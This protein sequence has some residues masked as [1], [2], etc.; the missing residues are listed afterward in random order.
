MKNSLRIFFLI[1]LATIGYQQVFAQRSVSGKVTASDDGS[2]LPGVNVILQGTD[3]G[4]ITD[5]N[6]DYRINIPEAGGTLVFSFIGYATQ[7][8]NIGNQSVI[9]MQLKPDVRQLTEVVVTAFGI[10]RERRSLNYSTQEVSAERINI[11]PQPNLT[12]ALQGKIAGVIVKQSSGMP[13][14]S[15]FVTIRGSASL[16]GANQPLYVVDGV[17]IESE[18]IFVDAATVSRVSG[19]DASS[20][21]LDINPEDV[22]SV[23]VLKGAAA[24][25]LYGLRASN[26]VILITTRRG[27]GAELGKPTV[28]FSTN[29]NLDRVTRLPR[30]QSTYSQGSRGTFVPGTS[31][32]W[33][34]R[35]DE[36]GTYINNVGEEVEGRVYDNQTPLFQTGGTLSS[37]INVAGRNENGN[38]SVG[39]G[40]TGQ[41][42]VIPTTG[43]ER[44]NAKFAGDY[45]LGSKWGVGASVNYSDLSVDKVPSGSNLSNPLFT[46]YF[47]PRSYDLWGTPY[48]FEDD[49]YRQI[50][51]RSNMDNPRWSLENNELS[52]QTRRTI[53]NILLSYNPL[54]WITFNYRLGLDQ[55]TTQA[56]EVYEKG[57]GETGGRTNP[58]SGGQITDF[59]FAQ[60]QINS[61]LNVTFDKNITE[62]IHIN[63]LAGNELYDIRSQELN[64]RGTG[65][66]IGGYHNMSNTA[67][68][69][70]SEIIN[71]NRVVG[72][73]GSLT[74]AWRRMLFLTATGRNDFVSN[75][76]TN[77]RSF[78]YPSLGGSFVFTEL[79]DLPENIISFGKVRAS[80]AQ[81]GQSAPNPYSTQNIF[82]Q[83][84]TGVGGFLNDGIQFPFA[85]RNAFTQSNIL[86]SNEL[87]PINTSTFE[88]GAEVRFLN[89]RINL[90][91]TYYIISATDQIFE[92]PLAPSTGFTDELRNAGE[93]ETKGHE[94]VLGLIPIQTSNFTWEI[95]ANY[96]SFTNKVVSLAPGVENIYLGGF[97]TPS[98]RAFAGQNYPS[99]F[100]VGYL[101]DDQGNI[102]L[103]NQ[104]GNPSHGM[105]IADPTA[106]V[107]GNA[108]PDFDIGITNAFSF[109][110]IS[111]MAQVDWRKGG[112]MYSGNSRLGR[113]YGILE[114]TEDRETPV[115][116]EGVKGNL[117]ADGSVVSE[118]VNDIAIVRGEQY[119]NTVLGDIDEA[120][121]HDASF[122]R[123][124]EISL[125]YNFPSRIYG[126]ALNNLHISLTA[127]N[128]FL[129]TKYPN[130][131]PETSTTGAVNGQGLEYVALPQMRSYGVSV[132][133]SF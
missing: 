115:V 121:V 23:S 29:Y 58:P 84:G 59:I 18:P 65:M 97:T 53:G 118:G 89:D 125:G 37:N 117:A 33:G 52:E 3:V 68:Q 36:L 39:L 48:A 87:R 61:N 1:F 42:G 91:Y 71:R 45:R 120:H 112:D 103:R 73:Y 78:F 132:R 81:V 114:V 67:S 34:P 6:G 43:M 96:T 64:V 13:G 60:N 110:G 21:S 131:D 27:K 106:K 15:S 56:K 32:S 76:P 57:S 46:T 88:V 35:I 16:S 93:L 101:R 55:F 25:A 79:L 24:A 41:S 31:L 69:I 99:I 133:L 44:I 4:A 62:E 86:R 104:P 63:F 10:E 49:P 90:D 54:E 74:A 98:I 38:Y 128:L 105:P 122:V 100:G 8:V 94:L 19:T 5:I 82:I 7:E 72:F 80:V 119:W 108:Q 70:I 14:A 22:E 127:R 51:Y 116:L 124:R 109:R 66:E 75:M 2:S 12:N 129:R 113:L 107:I 85:N 123:L 26:G 111:L 9:N 11:A 95:N 126:N 20:R 28:T 77:N 30:L 130:F 40:Y 83:G 17:P 50:H 102:V 47:A 92:V